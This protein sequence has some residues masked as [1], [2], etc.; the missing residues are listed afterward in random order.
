M[1][2]VEIQGLIVDITA[3]MEEAASNLEF[4]LAAEL[5]DRIRDLKQMLVVEKNS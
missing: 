3:M 1:K 2:S 4:E 5:R